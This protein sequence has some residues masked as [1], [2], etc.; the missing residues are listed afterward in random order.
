ML[1]EL[2]EPRSDAAPAALA[3]DGLLLGPAAD[4]SVP[5]VLESPETADLPAALFLEF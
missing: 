1:L 4:R 5:L 3:L 2:L